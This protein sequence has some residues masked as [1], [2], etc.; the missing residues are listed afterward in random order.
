MLSIFSIR[1]NMNVFEANNKRILILIG[2]I[3]LFAI[4]TF[5]LAAATL[6][7]LNNRFDS[8]TTMSTTST[9][10]SASLGSVLADTIR[11]DDLMNHL[12]QLQRIANENNRT[13]AIN[14]RGF[15]ETVNYIESYLK[16][17]GTGL[18]VNR[19]TFHVPNFAIASDPIFLSLIDGQEKNYTYSTKLARSDFTYVN[20]SN[21][22]NFSTFV[23]LVNIPNYGCNR[24][25][26]ENATGLVALVKAGGRCT[27]AEKG[28]LAKN[29]GVMALLFYNNGETNYNLAPIIIRVRYTNQLPAL[30]LSY[31]VG[32]ALANAS[33]FTNVLVKMSIQLKQLGTYPV[34]N[35]CADTIDGD[36]SQ[37]I[38]VGSHSDSA[39]AG[40]GINDNGKY[41]LLSLNLEQKMYYLSYYY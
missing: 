27:Y 15:N 33:E 11:I 4:A 38:V 31:T 17:Q 37:T 39:L 19:Q 7:T 24:S 10:T 30:Y 26:W 8:L 13:R 1:I 23:R 29:S 5:A 2:C 14:T 25:E 16:D 3:A 28:I 6:G 20:Y 41:S 36:K 34:D 18:N 35:I 9:T 32:R 21:S 12:R 22:A 40:P